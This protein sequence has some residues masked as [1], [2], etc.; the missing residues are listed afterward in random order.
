[1]MQPIVDKASQV[2]D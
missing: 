2:G 1:M